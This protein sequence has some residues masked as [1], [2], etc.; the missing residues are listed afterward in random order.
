MRPFTFINAAMS[1]DGKISTY[2]RKQ[3]RIS[4]SNDFQR[5]DRLRAGVDAVMVGIGTV[6]A[7]DPSLTIKSKDLQRQR[8]EQGKLENPIR[9]VVDSTAR[10]PIDADIFKKGDGIRIIAV[11]ES[12][13][14]RQV[15]ELKKKNR[16]RIISTGKDKVDLIALMSSLKDIGINSIMVEGGANLNWSLISGGLVDEI[17]IYTGALVL[18]GEK[19]PTLIDGSGFSSRNEAPGLELISVEKMDDGALLKWRIL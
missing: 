19:A 17:Y 15:E 7:D 6:L 5:V 13:P 18:G 8:K 1:A 16:T 3:I 14:V 11:S 2:L 10:I 4:G 12:A 9:I